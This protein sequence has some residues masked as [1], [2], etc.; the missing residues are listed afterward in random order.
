M[1]TSG[2]VEVGGRGKPE[3][4]A[5]WVER[6]GKALNTDVV[7]FQFPFGILARV[8]SLFLAASPHSCLRP[9]PRINELDELPWTLC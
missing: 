4:T 3:Q 8:L 2:Q 1:F 5:Q 7:S 6:A 9:G